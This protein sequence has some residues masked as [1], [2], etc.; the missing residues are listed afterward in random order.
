MKYYDLAGYNP[1]PQSEKEKGI[2]RYK[3][4]W[5]GKDFEYQKIISK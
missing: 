1:N 4:K 3:K 2:M 5:G